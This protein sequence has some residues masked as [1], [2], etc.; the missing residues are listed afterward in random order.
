MN[1][2]TRTV[3]K[4]CKT[5]LPKVADMIPCPQC[6]YENLP[7]SDVCDQCG[8]QVGD[9]IENDMIQPVAAPKAPVAPKAPGAPKAPSA[10]AAPPNPQ[11]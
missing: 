4:K 9:E 7:W 3:C 6:G 11:A 5:E 10:P 2:F 1:E 8:L